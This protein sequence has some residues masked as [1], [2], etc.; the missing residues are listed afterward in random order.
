MNLYNASSER[1]RK[2]RDGVRNKY[3][4]KPRFIVNFHT[5]PKNENTMQ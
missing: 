3:I 5:K 4:S 2:S 1:S